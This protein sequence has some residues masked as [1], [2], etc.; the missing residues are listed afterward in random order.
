M[1]RKIA[2]LTIVL[3]LLFYNVTGQ[4]SPGDLSA[5]HSHLEGISNCTQCHVL[6]NKV[7]SEKCLLCHTEIKQRLD[8]K[9]GFH[10]SSDVKGKDCTL[11]HNDH[12][13][14][15]FQ[16]VRFDIEKFD[17]NLTG[18][19]LSTPHAKKDCK[20]CHNIKFIKDQKIKSKKY[21]YLGLNQ[22][23]LTCHADYHQNT[24][25]P[26]C[27]NC[28]NPE[29]FKPATKFDHGS[30]RFHLEGKHKNV[31]CLKC[32]KVEIKDGKKYQLF[33]GIPNFNCVSCHKDPHQ[34]KFGLNCNQCHN[35]ESFL[36]IKGGEKFDHNKTDYKLEGKHIYVNCKACHKTKF[37]DP[38]KYKLCTDCHTD[39]HKK[40]FVKNGV[41]PDCSG[42]HN[43]KGFTLFSYTIEKHNTGVFPLNGGH[44]PVPCTDC[45]K[46]QKDWSFKG[47]GIKCFECHK[48]IHEGKIA[49]K[50]YPD[51]DCKVCHT[52]TRWNEVNFNHSLTEFKLTGAHAKATC[53]ECHFKGDSG[54][55]V[56]QKFAG[57]Q[58]NCTD[59]HPDNHFRQFEKNGI[60][61]CLQCHDTEKWKPSKF[62]HNNTDFKLTGKHINVPCEKCHKIQKEGPNIYVKYKI[63]NYKCESCHS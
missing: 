18:Y 19:S 24:L 14:K 45:H 57:L 44:L 13:G 46:K 7:S 3:L 51:S 29:A 61:D 39:Y 28:H 30:A 34:N 54:S 35:E 27:L 26:E 31:E 2:G 53:K 37:T 47:I 42:C 55:V 22:E 16:L 50:Y 62:D 25:S 52:D 5:F 21:T 9:K 49:P 10:V 11:C 40:Q 60:T 36:I 23:C 38:L 56:Q 58:K 59:C 4:I 20:D 17:H 32:H 43:L 6:G 12:H 63:I 8:L 33:K 1:T 41:S 15:T 48:D